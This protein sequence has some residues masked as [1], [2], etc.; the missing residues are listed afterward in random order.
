LISLPFCF[1][2]LCA[3][4]AKY[5]LKSPILRA[6]RRLFEPAPRELPKSGKKFGGYFSP[7]FSLK[8]MH[9]YGTEKLP[10]ACA[11][12]ADELSLTEV[13]QPRSEHALKCSIRGS[14]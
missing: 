7:L 1:P 5:G 14:S 13:G 9:V 6:F 12:H 10:F 11:E 8:S 2:S 3:G 4:E